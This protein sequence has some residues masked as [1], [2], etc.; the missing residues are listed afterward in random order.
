MLEVASG[1]SRWCVWQGHVMD[2]L[3]ALPDRSIQ[4]VVTSPPYFGLRDYG[5][6]P[7][8]W[9]GDSN[10]P[11]SWTQDAAAAVETTENVRWQ[12]TEGGHGQNRHANSGRSADDDRTFS[13]RD[14]SSCARCGAWKGALGLEPRLEMYVDHLIELFREVRRVLRDDGTLWLNLGDSYVGAMSQHREADS[15][16]ATSDIAEGTKHSVPQSGRVER[17]RAMREAGLKSKDLVGIPWRV[18]FALQADGWYLR[19]DIIWSKPNPMPESVTDRPTKAHEYLFLL[20]K[21]E[22]YFCDMDAIREPLAESSVARVNQP[23]FFDQAGG[24]KDYGKT[25]TNPNRSS[26][27][28][29]ENLAR[30]GRTPSGWNCEHKDGDSAGRY[31]GRKYEDEGSR[32]V[33]NGD[34]PNAGIQE[35]REEWRAKTRRNPN[36]SGRRQAPEPGEPNWAHPLGRNKRSVWEIPTQPFPGAHFATFPVALVEPAILAGTSARGSCGSCGSPYRRIVRQERVSDRPGRVQRPEGDSLEDAHGPDGRSGNR[37]VVASETVG[38]SPGCGCPPGDPVPC[39]VLDP[40]CGSGTAGM[41]ALHLGRRFVGVEI[42]PGYAQMA[43][44]RIRRGYDGKLPDQDRGDAPLFR[45]EGRG[46]GQP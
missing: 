18:A 38:W 8:V 23:T 28:A 30:W 14:S 10:C 5:I 15:F 16:G 17:G 19:S 43:T 32:D 45:E 13:S 26:R 4:C 22:R 35:A 31:P 36:V 9:G 46:H 42:N 21:S 40:F 1:A 39:A 25:G 11:H 41:V 27:R 3:R 7:V 20:A 24:D 34:P 33:R 44:E 6:D 37:L 12:H 2:G 29:L